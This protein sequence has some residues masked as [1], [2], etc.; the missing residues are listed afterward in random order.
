M[1][2]QNYPNSFQP[3]TKH[4]LRTQL[5]I[6]NS[7]ELCGVASITMLLHWCGSAESFADI[8]QRMKALDAF[9]VGKGTYLQRA[10]KLSP[11]L[12]YIRYM[13]LSLLKFFTDHHYGIA[14]SIKKQDGTNHIVFIYNSDRQ[15][16]YY[17]DP[18]MPS[19][20]QT[21]SRTEWR[22]VSNKR[23]I[24]MKAKSKPNKKP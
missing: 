17:F 2:S 16:V 7:D 23:A 12:R 14:A 8:F 24:I 11:R 13:P 5:H 4:Y 20:Q 21:L 1:T 9:V 22:R 3:I 19:A 18:N 15:H 6:T 10:V